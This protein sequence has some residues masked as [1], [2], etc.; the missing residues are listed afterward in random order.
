VMHRPHQVSSGRNGNQAMLIRTRLR[1][2]S[3]TLGWEARTTCQ[4]YA[5]TPGGQCNTKGD[6]FAQ[7]GM[8]ARST[9]RDILR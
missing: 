2:A 8:P 3:N 1:W 9:S 5:E 4:H 6:H 7:I